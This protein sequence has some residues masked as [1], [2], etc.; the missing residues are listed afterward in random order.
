MITSLTVGSQA[1]LSVIQG[2]LVATLQADLYDDLLLRIR[3]GILDRVH[4]AT[5]HGIVFDMSSV[6][7]LDSFM[8]HHLADTARMV[9]LL[10]AEA[11]FVGFQPGAA[12]VLVDVE[13]D[14]SIIRTFRTVGQG[15][16]NLI[17]SAALREGN[18][19]DREDNSPAAEEKR[20]GIDDGD[21]ESERGE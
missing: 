2:C 4:S 21:H 17:A 18:R 15:I 19:D 8:F 6:R 14:T 7:V 3:Q 5:I 11:V 20:A 1:A 13:V 9:R 10:G 12:S 16:E